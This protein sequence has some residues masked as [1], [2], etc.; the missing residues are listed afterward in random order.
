MGNI[1]DLIAEKESLENR[2]ENLK[3]KIIK[4]KLENLKKNETSKENILTSEETQL[5]K[6]YLEQEYDNHSIDFMNKYFISDEEYD[7]NQKLDN[8][9]EGSVC[10]IKLSDDTYLKIRE[11]DEINYYSDGDVREHHIGYDILSGKVLLNIMKKANCDY[12]R[13]GYDSKD[14]KYT[15]PENEINLEELF[16]NK[17]IDENQVDDNSIVDYDDEKLDCLSIEK[18]QEL[19]QATQAKNESKREQQRMS[20]LALLKQTIQEGKKLDAQIAEIKSKEDN[21]K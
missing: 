1:H 20:M 7:D 6:D 8:S 17:I 16:C 5:F 12:Y 21:Q 14:K 9:Y 11:I 3:F 10:V 15:L 4:A 2:L 13:E 19:L 18:I